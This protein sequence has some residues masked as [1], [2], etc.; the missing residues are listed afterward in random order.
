M[1]GFRVACWNKDGSLY[2]GAGKKQPVNRN[3]WR[4][5]G[6]KGPMDKCVSGRGRRLTGSKSATGQ[7]R[8]SWEL[9][10]DQCPGGTSET[11]KKLNTNSHFW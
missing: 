4:N 8:L 3:E 7:G 1:F 9:T 6:M 10:T 5:C 2:P 11:D